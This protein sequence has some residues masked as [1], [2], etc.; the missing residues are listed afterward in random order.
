MV[1]AGLGGEVQ[2]LGGSCVKHQKSTGSMEGYVLGKLLGGYR[3]GAGY[4]KRKKKRWKDPISLDVTFTDGTIGKI[5]VLPRDMPRAICLPTMPA[6]RLLT[7]LPPLKDDEEIHGSGF[8]MSRDDAAIKRF[9]KKHGVRTA[10]F[11]NVD[12]EAWERLLM[13]IA[14]CYAVYEYGPDG[15]HDF[16][17]PYILGDKSQLNHF[18]GGVGPND[19]LKT[20]RK[21]MLAIN[22]DERNGQILVRVR[23]F[24]YLGAPTYQVV[25]GIKRAYEWKAIRYALH[26]AR[27]K[28]ALAVRKLL[29]TNPFRV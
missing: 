11:G 25:V 7:G 18:V 27:V 28:V 4:P 29:P 24:A 16:L 23:L 14:H 21:I 12:P 15:F 1:P 6:P 9:A 17:V 10:E 5:D 13:K 19:E 22:I 3:G 2:L 8:W 20:R 26:G